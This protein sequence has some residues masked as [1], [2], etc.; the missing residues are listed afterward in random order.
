V[1]PALPHTLQ[2]AG[3]LK[4]K[5]ALITGGDSGIGRAVA[6]HFAREGASGIVIVYKGGPEDEDAIKT[7]GNP[8]GGCVCVCVYEGRGRGEEG[9]WP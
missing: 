5:R 4:G 3:K 8:G 1:K 7:V 2:A 6:V 9:G